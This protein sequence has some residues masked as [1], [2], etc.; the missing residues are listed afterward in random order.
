MRLFV[1]IHH[2]LGF[3]PQRPCKVTVAMSLSPGIR[4]FRKAVCSPLRNLGFREVKPL[5]FR[6]GEDPREIITFPVRFG[7]GSLYYSSMNLGLRFEDLQRILSPDD[8]ERP[9]IALPVHLLFPDR[10]WTEWSF[11]TEAEAAALVPNV[12][13]VL[14]GFAEP[15]WAKY[16]SLAVVKDSIQ[17]TN[18]DNHFVYSETQRITLIAAIRFSEGNPGEAVEYLGRL[19]AERRGQLPK[20]WFPLRRVRDTMLSII[21]GADV[22]SG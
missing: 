1:V 20:F 7:S 11:K 17:S 15:F 8:L 18:S 4:I 14:H 22:K 21:Q 19:I 2:C 12:V 13:E 6:R 9:T 5:C 16:S 10:K 3:A